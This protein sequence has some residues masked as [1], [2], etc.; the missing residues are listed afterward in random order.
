MLDRK[1]VITVDEEQ[2]LILFKRVGVQ[3]HEHAVDGMNELFSRVDSTGAE[4][5]LADLRQ[6]EVGFTHSLLG[7]H[8]EMVRNEIIKRPHIRYAVL[9]KQGLIFGLIRLYMKLKAYPNNLAAFQT[10]EKALEWLGVE[11]CPE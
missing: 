6:A 5:I 4:K 1:Y 7:N 11:K 2:R 9:A 10:K 3:S 8:A